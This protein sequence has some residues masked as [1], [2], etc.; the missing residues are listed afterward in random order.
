VSA[1][2]PRPLY[3]LPEGFIRFHFVYPP[4]SFPLGV[5]SLPPCKIPLSADPLFNATHLFGLVFKSQNTV[6][7]LFP[8]LPPPYFL[9][10]DLNRFCAMPNSYPDFFSL[11]ACFKNTPCFPL[12]AS[13]FCRYSYQCSQLH[14]PWRGTPPRSRS[15]PTTTT[16][17]SFLRLG[18]LPPLANLTRSEGFFHFLHLSSNPFCF[19]LDEPPVLPWILQLASSN[20]KHSLFGTIWF[21]LSG[22]I[23]L[24]LRVPVLLRLVVLYDDLLLP[25]KTP[26]T[27]FVT[28]VQGV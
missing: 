1:R 7:S 10:G 5:A 4:P 20:L 12:F 18:I 23:L 11:K 25:P 2:F 24:V 3:P 28:G 8:P 13:L 6:I 14:T 26:I 17:S 21:R 19:S 9:S 16:V 15:P 22:E 27:N